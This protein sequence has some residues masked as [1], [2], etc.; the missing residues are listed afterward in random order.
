[1]SQFRSLTLASLPQESVGLSSLRSLAAVRFTSR[2]PG[3]RFVSARLLAGH[4]DPTSKREVKKKTQRRALIL[5]TELYSLAP[6]TPGKGNPQ[7]ALVGSSSYTGPT[8]FAVTDITPQL[9]GSLC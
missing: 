9:Q 3:L 2:P 6:I 4:T 5:I 8:P 1:L 7:I